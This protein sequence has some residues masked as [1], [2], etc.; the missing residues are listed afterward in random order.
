VSTSTDEYGT[1]TTFTVASSYGVD[2]ESPY[3]YA[4]YRDASGA[5]IG[6]T[7]GFVDMVPAGGRASGTVSSY[8]PVPNVASAEV[9]VDQG[10][11]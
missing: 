7:Y 5:I 4:I 8:E 1:D 11:F 9:Y 2:L 6:G 10:F 3:A